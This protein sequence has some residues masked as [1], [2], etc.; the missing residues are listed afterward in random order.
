MKRIDK[1]VEVSFNFQKVFFDFQRLKEALEGKEIV[2]CKSK[3][4]VKEIVNHFRKEWSLLE[5]GEFEDGEAYKEVFHA[6][7]QDESVSFTVFPKEG[8]CLVRFWYSNAGW[9]YELE[10]VL[11]PEGIGWN[12]ESLLDAMEEADISRITCV[13][14]L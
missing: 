6:T 3:E 11:I 12:K 13:S 5:L 8:I 9:E 7:W 2:S 4:D 14:S 10:E 1:N